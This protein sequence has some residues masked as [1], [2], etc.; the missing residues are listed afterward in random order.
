MHKVLFLQLVSLNSVHLIP[1][2]KGLEK[3]SH[4]QLTC[5]YH[6]VGATLLAKGDRSSPLQSAHQTLD[7]RFELFGEQDTSTADSYH[8]L[9]ATLFA[10]G[11][12]SSAPQAAHR[13]LD[14]WFE[15]F[16]EQHSS[17]AGS[18]HLLGATQLAQGDFSSALQSA[19]RALD[20]R[21][22]LFG[23]E[24][25]S[26]AESYRLLAAHNLRKATLPQ[27]FSQH[28]VHWISGLNSLE[29]AN[30]YHSLGLIQH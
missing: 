2:L 1:C 7:F 26:T 28:S 22:K 13:A 21:L 4:T 27:L 12:R 14:F 8:S 25:S 9:G 24:H 3:N 30:S 19:Q 15:L 16:G 5:S 17:T 29:K 10:K 23:E 18:Y 6:S 11:D 20:I